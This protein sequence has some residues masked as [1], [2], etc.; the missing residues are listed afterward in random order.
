[1][2]LFAYGTLMFPEVWGRVV[3]RPFEVRR[4]TLGGFAVYRAVG[5][6][7]PVM[8]EAGAEARVGGLVYLG[9]DDES[10][11][12][13]DRYESDLYERRIVRAVTGDGQMLD[14]QA[15]VLP[16]SRRELASQ[17]LWDADWFRREALAG[18]LRALGD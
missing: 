5:G 17:I 6:E 4:A 9:V 13:L 14:C 12:L 8:V 3:A 11:T 15:Y 16:A 7:Y 2:H 18:Y 1:M 10:L